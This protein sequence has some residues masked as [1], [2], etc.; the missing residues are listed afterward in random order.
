M[1]RLQFVYGWHRDFENI[2][3]LQRGH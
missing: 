1:V 3:K 2:K